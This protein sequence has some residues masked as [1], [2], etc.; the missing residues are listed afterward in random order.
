VCTQFK[1]KA[2]KAFSFL[3]IVVA[4]LGV[5]TLSSI[6]FSA[7]AEFRPYQIVSGKESFRLNA[8]ALNSLEAIGLTLTSVENLGLPES[9]YDFA[10]PVLPPPT[11]PGERGTTSQFVY[12]EITDTFFSI[13]NSGTVEFDGSFF[14]EVDPTRFNLASPLELGELSVVFDDVEFAAID[15]VTTNI[16]IITVN[17][18]AL[19]TVDLDNQMWFIEP[20]KLL[21]TQEFS[22]FLVDASITQETADQVAAL[23]PNLQIGEG[24][25]D[26]G[27]IPLETNSVPEP[28]SLIGIFV[29]AGIVWI[30]KKK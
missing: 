15:T 14:F 7:N 25:V 9:G 24:R 28:S 17:T 20:V 10:W 27:F 18:D 6:P 22:D 30:A 29:M 5:A 26:R 16:S 8:D 1:I 2:M 19:P 13:P 3:K 23:I 21:L 11:T 4:T 12:D